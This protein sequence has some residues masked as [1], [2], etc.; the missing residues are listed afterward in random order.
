MLTEAAPGIADER[1]GRFESCGGH[2]LERRDHMKMT[3]KKAE[4]I[5]ASHRREI[6]RRNAPLTTCVHD[7]MLASCVLCLGQDPWVP[8]KR[9]N[10]NGDTEMVPVNDVI[11]TKH[12]GRGYENHTGPGTVL[13]DNAAWVLQHAQR[14]GLR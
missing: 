6:A 8:S 11:S 4:A 12:S 1:M 3:V 9:P 13:Y 14:A 7:I 5:L 2:S 10:A